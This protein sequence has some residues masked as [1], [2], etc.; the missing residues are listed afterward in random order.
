ML[1]QKKGRKQSTK[2]GTIMHNL[3]K[4][5]QKQISGRE[6][7]NYKKAQQQAK[8]VMAALKHGLVFSLS[9][10]KIIGDK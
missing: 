10:R 9:E 1:I 4:L 2:R 8:E 7:Y 5:K 3:K 6:Y